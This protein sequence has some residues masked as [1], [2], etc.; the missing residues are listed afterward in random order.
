MGKG[1][2]TSVHYVITEVDGYEPEIAEKLRAF[3]ALDD[4][5]PALTPHHLE[6]G[7][8]WLVHLAGEAAAFGGLVPFEPFPKTGYLKRAYVL[9]EHRGNGLQGRLLAIRE[10]KARGLKWTHL[11]SECASTNAPSANNFIRAGFRVCEPE[12][13]WGAPGSIY[14]VK[15]I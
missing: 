12:Q 5:F 10:Q 6:N 1:R 7:F 4:H 8:W 14:W 2:F 13:R 9:P 3:N 15:E 11:V